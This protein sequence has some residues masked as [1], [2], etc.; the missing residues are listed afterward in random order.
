MKIAIDISQIIYQTGV[1]TYTRELVK[2]L[3]KVDKKNE[4]ILFG[5]SLR[6]LA[7]L[8]NFA[9]SLKGNFTTRFLPIPPTAADMLWNRLHVGNVEN[10]IGNIDV[11]HTSDWAQAPTKAYKVTT[12]HDLTPLLL[13]NQTHPKIV[14]THKRRL[15][16]IKKD[17]DMVIVPSKSA[18]SDLSKLGIEKS[19]IVSIAEAPSEQYKPRSEK[20]VD[21]LKNKYG[22]KGKYFLAVGNAPRKNISR[23]IQGFLKSQSETLIENL[24]IV[25]RGDDSYLHSD[26]IIFTGHVPDEDLPVFYS[27]AE[28]LLYASLYEGFG[29][30]ILEAFACN[31]PVLISN[32]SSLPE[33]AGDAAVQVNPE[34]IDS[35]S[36]GIIELIKDKQKWVKKGTKRV[37]DF[38]WEKTARKTLEIYEQAS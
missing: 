23:T 30:P 21:I 19:R 26:N 33:V 6:R 5:G 25:G 34:S 29:L 10:F 16:W 3:L 4:Y 22:I 14:A 15:K 9:D 31:T 36:R 28:A 13:P 12:V 7:E 27:G 18:M 20:E 32:V 17:V 35:I 38:S 37:K 1:S 8:Q 24:V 11:F 2:A